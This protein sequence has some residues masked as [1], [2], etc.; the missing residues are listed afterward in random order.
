MGNDTGC[1][2][3]SVVPPKPKRD[4]GLHQVLT[5]IVLLNVALSRASFLVFLHAGAAGAAAASAGVRSVHVVCCHLST[6]L[7][8]PPHLQLQPP[9][10]PS[11]PPPQ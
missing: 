6:Q 3:Y 4:G 1:T 2:R 8:K 10:P 9:P 7:R 5:D 11:P